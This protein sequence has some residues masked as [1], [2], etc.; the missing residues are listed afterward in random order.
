[1]NDFKAA[2]A[3]DKMG[4]AAEMKEEIEFALSKEPLCSYILDRLA[5][6][7][8]KLCVTHND[9]KLNNVLMDAETGDGVCI[10]DLDT[11]MPGSVLYDFG[12]AI[13]F[14]ASSAAEDETDLSKVYMDL[15]MFETYVK[16]FVGELHDSM[17]E[18]E[19]LSLPMGAYLMTLETGIRFLGDYLNGD[20]Y[21]H[22]RY[23]GHNKDR[24]RNQLKL[25]ADMDEKMGLMQEIVKKYL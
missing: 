14:G 20:V 13:R 17:T 16:G 1:M 8:C 2:V 22:T 6:G 21:F 23:E 5:D 12:D 15:E 10:I 24:A 11:V 18:E 7:R 4:R 9:T 25:I 3:E 19:I